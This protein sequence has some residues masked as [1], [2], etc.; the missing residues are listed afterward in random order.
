MG[1]NLHVCGYLRCGKAFDTPLRLT[2][3]S[4]K[5]HSETYYACPYCFSKVDNSGNAESSSISS[6]LKRLHGGGYGLTEREGAG[7]NSRDP[8]Q[9]ETNK[10]PTTNCPHHLG[11]LKT[12]PKDEAVPDSCFVCAKI[13]QCLA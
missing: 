2:D 12:R 11:Y 7:R 5:P 1:E 8:A 3:L 6:E 13:L 9:K 4:H 10:A